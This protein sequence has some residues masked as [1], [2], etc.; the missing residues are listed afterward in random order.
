[1]NTFGCPTISILVIQ[2]IRTDF[3]CS[4]CKNKIEPKQDRKYV[5]ENQNYIVFNFYN[6]ANCGFDFKEEP[7]IIP[8]YESYK[9]LDHDCFEY[10]ETLVDLPLNLGDNIVKIEFIKINEGSGTLYAR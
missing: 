4:N 2:K 5:K 10:R 7:K 8:E 1:M 9:R 3:L 6:C